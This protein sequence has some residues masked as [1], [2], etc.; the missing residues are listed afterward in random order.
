MNEN[1]IRINNLKIWLQ[2]EMKVYNRYIPSIFI[3][4][5]L[6]LYFP[7]KDDD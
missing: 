2:N 4:L 1:D 7:L 3:T 5:A 6:L